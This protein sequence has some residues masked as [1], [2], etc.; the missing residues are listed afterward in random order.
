MGPAPHVGNPSGSSEN[1]EKTM[2]PHIQSGVLVFSGH[3]AQDLTSSPPLR[4]TSIIDLRSSSSPHTL[5][6][7]LTHSHIHLEDEEVSSGS[8]VCE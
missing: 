6:H 3:P 1:L 4:L 2:V 7:T 8:L 5:T